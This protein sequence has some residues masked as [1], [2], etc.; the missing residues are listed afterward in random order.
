ME[1]I[2][3]RS[4]QKSDFIDITSDINSI[5]P[6]DFSGGCVISSLHTTGGITVNENA[7]PDVVHDMLLQLDEMVPWSNPGFKHMEGNSAAHV[8]TSLMGSS[9]Y[10]PVEN[11]RLVLGTWQ[12]VYF[13]EFDGPRSRRVAVKF[14]KD[15]GVA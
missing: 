13:C 15:A 2:N 1:M 8:K 12:S 3:I 9:L 6:A 11:S 10:L 7:D 4:R 14:F 5:I